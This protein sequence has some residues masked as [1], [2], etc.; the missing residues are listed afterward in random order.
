MGLANAV[1]TTAQ[2]RLSESLM[3]TAMMSLVD[4]Q[5]GRI[6]YAS[7]GD[8]ISNTNGTYTGSN[9]R[10]WPNTVGCDAI[11]GPGHLVPLSG[12]V[13]RFVANCGFSGRASYDLLGAEPATSPASD[14]RKG[15]QDAAN[16]GARLGYISMGINDIQVGVT[17]TSTAEQINTFLQTTYSNLTA[18][19]GRCW[20]NGILPV[21]KNI[22]GYEYGSFATG[23]PSL[24]PNGAADAAARRPVV[25]T[26]NAYVRDVLIPSLPYF[27]GYVDVFSVLCNSDGTYK[28]GMS[29]DGLHPSTLGAFIEAKT[30]ITYLRGVGI[31][32]GRTQRSVIPNGGEYSRNVFRN[33]DLSNAGGSFG[34]VDCYFATAAVGSGGALTYG[35]ATVSGRKWHATSFAPSSS[36]TGGVYAFTVYY[37]VRIYGGS[38]DMAVSTNDLMMCECDVVVD[39]GAGGVPLGYESVTTRLRTA[40][41]L[42]A[43]ADDI[44]YTTLST[45]AIGSSISA[46]LELHPVVGPL[47]MREAS[48]TMTGASVEITVICATPDPVRLLVSGMRICRVPSTY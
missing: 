11:K 24:F 39:N 16:S 28:A 41:T 43:Y 15:I 27:V 4:P 10:V 25:A 20:A 42:P 31:L 37:N 6:N 9:Y 36:G 32:P 48:A 33:P 5:T 8:S 38:P 23:N 3:S 13:L 14:T 34:A 45:H 46:P 26:L 30:A 44:A 35:I 22:A 29:D 12:G 2:K 47:A 21:Y 40:G 1:L 19:F 7:I 18:I 17:S